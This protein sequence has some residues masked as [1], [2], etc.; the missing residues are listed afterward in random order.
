M[1]IVELMAEAIFLKEGRAKDVAWKDADNVLF[2][3]PANWSEK[4][5]SPTEYY[6]NI[7]QAA[8]SAL[9]AAGYVVVPREPT[10]KM[11]ALHKDMSGNELC[12]DANAE[13][14]GRVWSI[15]LE[16]AKETP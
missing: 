15:M 11:L 2:V 13:V 3:A 16:A 10:E 4:P 8:L 12:W 5:P 1:T 9:E 6:R 14:V 7:A